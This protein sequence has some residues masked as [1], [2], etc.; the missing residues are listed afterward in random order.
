MLRVTLLF[1]GAKNAKLE[2]E[3]RNHP[4]ASASILLRAFE[5]DMTLHVSI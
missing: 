3:T 1:K 2:R 4:E 5:D